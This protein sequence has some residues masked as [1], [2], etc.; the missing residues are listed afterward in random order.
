MKLGLMRQKAR[1]QEY[2]FG[3]QGCFN[4]S[5]MR[6]LNTAIAA[7][8]YQSVSISDYINIAGA[9]DQ[10]QLYER[11]DQDFIL[12]RIPFTWRPLIAPNIYLVNNIYDFCIYGIYSFISPR[13]LSDIYNL[14]H[15][16]LITIK[17]ISKWDMNV[18]ISGHRHRVGRD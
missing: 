16:Q 7:F 9:S 2:S 12:A 8:A 1:R 6:G 5:G 15:L 17:H 3:L 18:I 14:W 10:R 13:N 11:I 4:K